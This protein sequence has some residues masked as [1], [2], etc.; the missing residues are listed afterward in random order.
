MALI[1]LIG[2][3]TLMN[4]ISI[5]IMVSIFIVCVVLVIYYRIKFKRLD[6]L[7]GIIPPDGAAIEDDDDVDFGMTSQ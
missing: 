6:G 7:I 4:R 3:L 2:S 5:G 1:R